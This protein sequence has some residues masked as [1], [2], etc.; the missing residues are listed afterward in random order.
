MEQAGQAAQDVE[1]GR[2]FG[3]LGTCYDSLGDYEEVTALFFQGGTKRPKLCGKIYK[4][5]T[6]S[7]C[8]PNILVGKVFLQC[9]DSWWADTPPVIRVAD[10]VLSR[11]IWTKPLPTD[12]LD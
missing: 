11:K 3:N 9:T 2:A 12:M 1:R 7:L 8:Q 6:G 10:Q 4:W 5:N